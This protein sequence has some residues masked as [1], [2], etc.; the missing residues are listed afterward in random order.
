LFHLQHP[1]VLY[2][3][4]ERTW[5]GNKKAALPQGNRAMPILFGLKFANEST[6]T[7]QVKCRPIGLT[8]E[9][10]TYQRIM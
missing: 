6:T 5:K 7:I 10:Q 8:S 2:G 3:A 1:T 4:R 9:L